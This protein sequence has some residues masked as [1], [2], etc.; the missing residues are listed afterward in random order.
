TADDLSSGGFGQA[1]G[2]TRQWTNGKGYD[3]AGFDGN[4]TVITQLAYL[5]TDGTDVVVVAGA[6]SGEYFDGSFG[7]Y[8]PRD[9]SKDTLTQN[10]GAKE[11]TYVTSD[12][13]KLVFNNFDASL[14]T[15]E[16]GQIKSV[17][18]PEGNT[19]SVTSRTTD[20]KPTEMQRSTTIGGTTT[21][22]SYLY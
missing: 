16:K 22:E 5:R 17:T 7:S 3:A 12:G 18:D 21:T 1:W 4:G 20:G 10:T 6:L 14:A 9:Y 13:S 8:T 19:T 15:Y 11:F 2:V